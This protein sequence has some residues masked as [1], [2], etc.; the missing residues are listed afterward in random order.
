MALYQYKAIVERIIDGD[1]V[2]LTIDLGFNVTLTGQHVRLS[3]NAPEIRTR[4]KE[5]KERGIA[6]RD[7]LSQLIPV[8]SRCILVSESF[9]P[10]KG[11]YGRIIGDILC[12]SEDKEYDDE[13]VSY[14]MTAAGHIE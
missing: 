1:T 11:K 13:R 6:S 8:G 7:Y 2:V 3:Y 5:E 14:L 10:T 4:D 12:V 9:N